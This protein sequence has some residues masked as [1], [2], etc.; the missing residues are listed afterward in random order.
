MNINEIN[1]AVLAYVGDA[2][3]ELLIRK[4]LL[5]KN[6]L[7]VDTLQKEAVKYVSAEAQEKLLD[8]ILSL[9][10]LD[11]NELY[12]VNRSKNYKPNSKPRHASILT[13]K[14]ATALEALFGK[15]YL[16]HNE[17]RIEEIFNIIIGG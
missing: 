4:Y 13:Y 5:Q 11:S 12:T 7:K 3:Y 9:N 6:I 8:L 16:E 10:I 1:P 17:C 14:K 2:I 15:L